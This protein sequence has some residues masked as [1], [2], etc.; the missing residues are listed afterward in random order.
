VVE[1]G[2]DSMLVVGYQDLWLCDDNGDLVWHRPYG[3]QT[4]G[5]GPASL[6]PSGDVLVMAAHLGSWPQDPSLALL[7]RFDHTGVIEDSLVLYSSPAAPLYHLNDMTELEEGGQVGLVYGGGWMGLVRTDPEGDTLWTR[8]IGWN[9][10]IATH[11]Y[12]SGVREL[13]DHTIAVTGFELLPDTNMLGVMVFSAEGDPICMVPLAG[14]E[15]LS[16]GAQASCSVGPN[17][18]LHMLVPIELNGEPHAVLLAGVQDP[19]ST[20]PTADLSR[21]NVEVFPNPASETLSFSFDTTPGKAGF[22]L[23]DLYGRVVLAGNCTAA[24]TTLNLAG[25]ASGQY[26][27]VI[28]QEGWKVHTGPVTIVR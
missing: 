8:E 17:G 19:C 13:S 1:W 26:Q 28:Q 12:C 6:L 23:I 2:T 18:M 25:L 27:L 21:A 4:V 10:D 7:L 15:G 9:T 11:F 14:C 24:T 3:A 5:L 20:T 22:R 16:S